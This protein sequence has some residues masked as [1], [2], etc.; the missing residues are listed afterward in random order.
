MLHSLKYPPLEQINHL[1]GKGNFAVRKYYKFPYR[2]FYRHK[3]A[4]IV[5]M[6]GKSH[7]N[8]LLDFGSGSGIFIPELKRHANFVTLVDR[9]S[10]IKPEWRFNAIVCAS[11]LEFVSLEF[12]LH[13]L[14]GITAPH[15]TIFVASPMD[16]PLSQF[17]FKLIGDKNVR[18]THKQI[19]LAV[20]HHY[21]LEEYTEWFGLYFCLKARKK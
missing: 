8:R 10:V 21:I 15:G 16:T 2:W 9:F 18:N 19:K 4:M 11:V 5:K 6:M 1:E 13:I 17:Y 3:L 12:I 14:H 7:Y 20:A